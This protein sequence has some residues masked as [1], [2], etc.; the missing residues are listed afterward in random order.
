MVGLGENFDEIKELIY[1]LS[2]AQVD[3]LTVGQY[4]QPSKNH[5]KVEKYYSLEEFKQIEDFIKQ[6]TKILP[7]VSPL[8]RSSY[9]AFE[10]Y[11]KVCAKF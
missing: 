3:I 11:K 4:I 6:N 1:D 9:K 2:N 7:V 5:L 8:A 10:S